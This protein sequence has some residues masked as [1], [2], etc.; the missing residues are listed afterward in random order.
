MTVVRRLARPLLAAAF[1]SRGID[2]LRSPD[3]EAAAAEP[4]AAPLAR[5]VP[6]LPSDPRQLARVTGGVQVA[7]GSL[8]ALGR[9]PR[10]S[11]L[12]LAASTLPTAATRHRF[13][14]EQD[15]A[16]RAEQQR[17]LVRE[18]GLLGGV[19]LAAVDTSGSPSL[20]WRARHAAKTSRHAVRAGKREAKLAARAARHR[21]RAAVS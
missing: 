18:L 12:L 14:Q 15:K 19:L 4:V 10:V 20:G 7:A 6:Y 21:A 17:E 2:Q 16:A 9:L 5:R 11:A 1:V 8:L 13:W 3:E